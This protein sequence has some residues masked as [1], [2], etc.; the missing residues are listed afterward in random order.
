MLNTSKP[1]S[2][3]QT[4]I[5]D[6][7]SSVIT[8]PQSYLHSF[9]TACPRSY[10]PNSLKTIKRNARFSSDAKNLDSLKAVKKKPVRII[11]K[12]LWISGSKTNRSNLARLVFVGSRNAIFTSFGVKSMYRFNWTVPQRTYLYY[13]HR[14]RF[15][16]IIF[17]TCELRNHYFSEI[18]KAIA[19]RSSVYDPDTLINP[20]FR[21]E[22]VLLV[23][24][25]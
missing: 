8:L 6:R 18:A 7:H 23:L 11:S 12:H 15:Q 3:H 14:K 2:R 25:F 17:L 5:F 4:N 1:W 10:P 21:F 19:I 16:K 24:S 9:F 13:R 20:Q 22:C